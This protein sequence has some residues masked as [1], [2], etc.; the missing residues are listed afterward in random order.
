MT[1]KE[2]Y[3]FKRRKSLKLYIKMFI[4]IAIIIAIIPTFSKYTNML[5]VNSLIPIAKWSIKINDVPVTSTSAGSISLLNV[6]DD[7][8]QIDSGDT[9]YFEITIDPSTT[10]VSVSY[11]IEVDLENDSNLPT[12][13]IIEKYEKYTYTNNTE[14]LSSTTNVNDTSISL[15]PISENIMLP[16]T[17]TTLDSSSKVKYKFY[18]KIPFPTNITKNAAFTVTPYILVEQFISE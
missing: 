11:D 2:H 8:T 18:C 16:N 7:S 3:R 15:K 13:T 10:E 5:S 12:G 9:C 14:T 1:L 6:E 4:L 17:Q